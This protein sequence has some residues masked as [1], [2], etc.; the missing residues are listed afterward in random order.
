[1]QNKELMLTKDKGVS[2]ILIGVAPLFTGDGGD[3]WP[4]WYPNPDGADAQWS[5]PF[6]EFVPGERSSDIEIST[7]ENGTKMIL[8][9]PK[10]ATTSRTLTFTNLENGLTATFTIE[11]GKYSSSYVKGDVFRLIDYPFEKVRM[12]VYPPP[13]DTCKKV[14]KVFI[15]PLKEGVVNAQQEITDGRCWQCLCENPHSN[16]CP[17]D[18][19]SKVRR[20]DLSRRYVFYRRRSNLRQHRC[21]LYRVHSPKNSSVQCSKP[22]SR[23]GRAKLQIYGS[24]HYET[25]GTNFVLRQ[26]TDAKEALYA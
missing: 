2:D 6:W 4:I 10:N 1:M 22:A 3:L 13:Q 18:C 9:N 19:I 23:I 17:R 15:R 25:C 12:K 26:L 14:K 7:G 11:A 5:N 21:S 16:L 24:R 8:S 20:R